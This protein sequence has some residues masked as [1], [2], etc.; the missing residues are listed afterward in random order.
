MRGQR[1]PVA[2]KDPWGNEKLAFETETTVSRKE[3]GLNWNAALE[4]G[5]FLVGDEVTI[6]PQIQAAYGDSIPPA[7]E[8]SASAGPPSRECVPVPVSQSRGGATRLFLP[9]AG[10]LDRDPDFVADQ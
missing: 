6:S 4:T 1:I 8:C 7:R 5:G 9:D 10:D 2:A 3:Y